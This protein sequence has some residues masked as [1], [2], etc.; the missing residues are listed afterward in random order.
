V[1]RSDQKDLL[2]SKWGGDLFNTMTSVNDNY[3]GGMIYLSRMADS[4]TK[5]FQKYVI[6]DVKEK[7]EAEK[8]E[9]IEENKRGGGGGELD[10][11][12]G[13]VDM[14]TYLQLSMNIFFF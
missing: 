5:T 4:E 12:N 10:L 13:T 9:A 14:C 6:K 7:I 8:I 2:P 11:F 3:L 1:L